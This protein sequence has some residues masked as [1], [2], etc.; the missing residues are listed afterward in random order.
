MV[1]YHKLLIILMVLNGD[2]YKYY[3][4]YLP[5][6]NIIMISCR[7]LLFTYSQNY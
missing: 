5:N 6:V 7:Y 4:K 2:N 3:D 1:V